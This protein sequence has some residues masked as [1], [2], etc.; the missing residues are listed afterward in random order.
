[1]N[2][3]KPLENVPVP[4]FQG[5]LANLKYFEERYLQTL[6]TKGGSK[7]QHALMKTSKNLHFKLEKPRVIHKIKTETN[8]F[9]VTD[10]NTIDM[11]PQQKEELANV[12]ISNDGTEEV[13]KA[14]KEDN[15]KLSLRAKI[16]YQ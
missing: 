12:V 14:R 9:D 1:M 3:E 13:I 8:E 16:P 11:T 15:E 10:V 4:D 2:Q 6:K 5:V 7:E